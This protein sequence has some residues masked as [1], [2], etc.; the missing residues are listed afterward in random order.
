MT[1]SPLIGKPAPALSL[2]D[3]NGETYNLTPDSAGVPIALFFYPK[4]GESH[5][6]PLSRYM[7]FTGGFQVLMAAQRRL[8]S[9]A[10][11]WQVSFLPA[12]RV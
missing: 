11:P 6:Q 2:P 8:A 12:Y 10:M 7:N 4:S 1:R 9:S 3:A 5:F